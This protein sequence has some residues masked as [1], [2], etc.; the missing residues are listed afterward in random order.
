ML[1][2][3]PRPHIVQKE[4]PVPSRP[5]SILADF[6]DPVKTNPVGRYEIELLFEVGEGS[7]PFNPANHAWDA[8]KSRGCGK[9][10]FAVGIESQNVVTKMLA[11][12]EK[13]T[14]AGSKIENA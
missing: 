14:G 3:Q 12:V 2:Q 1:G 4:F 9:K 8:E 5:L 6:A 13:I 11:D 10:R 7:L